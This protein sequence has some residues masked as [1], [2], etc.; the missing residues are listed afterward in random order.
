MGST[1]LPQI[2]DKIIYQDYTFWVLVDVKDVLQPL[3]DPVK[4]HKSSRIFGHKLMLEWFKGM[5]LLQDQGLM[6]D[7]VDLSLALYGTED[8]PVLVMPL[9]HLRAKGSPRA[10]KKD[11]NLIWNGK[12]GAKKAVLSHSVILQMMGLDLFGSAGALRQY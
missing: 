4:S 5:V 7:S 11:P 3:F 1:I 12:I 9:P 8:Q 10:G 6:F 2:S